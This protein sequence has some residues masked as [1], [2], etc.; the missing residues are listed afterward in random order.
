[1]AASWFGPPALTTLMGTLVGAFLGLLE[2]VGF[3][4][5]GDDLGVVDQTIDHGDDT[6]GVGKDL[7]PFREGAVGRDQGALPL[8]ATTDQL[9]QKI[10]MAV[11]VGQITDLID[12]QESGG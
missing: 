4:L 8:V 2:A 11:G 7:P 10:G 5:N 6:G 3:A 12:H 9:E 1:M